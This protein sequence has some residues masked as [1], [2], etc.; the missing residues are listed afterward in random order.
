MAT[1]LRT[2]LGERESPRDAPKDAPRVIV[3]GA[4]EINPRFDP[5]RYSELVRDV[6]RYGIVVLDIDGTIRSWNVAATRMTGFTEADTLGRPFSILFSLGTEPDTATRVLDFARLSGHHRGETLRIRR[7]GSEFLA[8]STIDPI[9]G[10][11]GVPIGFIEIFDDITERRERE[12]LLYRQATRDALT[13]TLNRGHFIELA[14]MEV[15]RAQRFHESLSLIMLD[16]DHFKQ[17]NDQYGHSIGDQVL[18]AFAQRLQQCARRTDSVGRLGGE[19]FCVLLPRST[20]EAAMLTA[21]RLR[22][23]IG[24]E[25][26]VTDAGLLRVT[27]S[28][29]AATL[30]PGMRDL[31]DLMRHAD[32]ALYRAKQMGRD[33]AQQ[34]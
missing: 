28:L 23:R 20:I 21:E 24:T 7:D 10:E 14:E 25:P 6:R 13:D 26:F 34:D 16:I 19:E 2:A 32:H 11:D 18:V 9:R 22:V 1:K 27:A 31:R 5:A 15:A 29:G 30:G 33:Q 8:D 3:D 4:V 17:I 12:H